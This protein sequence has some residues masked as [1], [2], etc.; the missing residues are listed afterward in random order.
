MSSSHVIELYEFG[1]GVT[2]VRESLAVDSG[3]PIMMDTLHGARSLADVFVALSPEAE[4]VPAAVLEADA[5]TARVDPALVPPSELTR[6]SSEFSELSVPSGELADVGRAI[7]GVAATTCSADVLKDGWGGDWFLG[8]Y[9]TTGSF[10]DC[11]KN[12]GSATVGDFS[13]PWAS[14]RQMEG[15]FNLPGH[16]AGGHWYCDSP[17]PGIIA[18]GWRYK[19]DFDYDVLPRRIEIWNWAPSS[20]ADVRGDSQCG[21]LH[22]AFLRN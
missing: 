19:V 15:D 20:H 13:R 8:K 16:I 6:S 14:W 18:C 22:V 11:I 5:R 21:H 2:A 4:E 1:P 17:L 12:K 9:C 7:S 3:E 10:R